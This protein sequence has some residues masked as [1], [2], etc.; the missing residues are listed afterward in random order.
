MYKENFAEALNRTARLGLRAP[1]V[2]MTEKMY[3]DQETLN[4]LP[5]AMYKIMGEI[6]VDDLVAKC[7]SIHL[8]IKPVIEEVLACEAFYTIGWVSY[9][10]S[11][12]FK[13]TE[14]SLSAMLKNG[15]SGPNVSLHAWLTLPSME[16]LDFSL[17]TTYAKIYGK[18]EGIGGAITMHPSKLTGGMMYHPMLVGDEFLLKT[19]AA[20]IYATF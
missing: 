8:R 17:P 15:I 20:R 18:K 13:Q 1:P 3:L 16:I 11:S 2:R 4:K 10:K 14:E 19:G 6:S 7:L 12:I 5:H 9:E